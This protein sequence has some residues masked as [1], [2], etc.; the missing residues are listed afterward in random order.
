MCTS[1]ENSQPKCRHCFVVPISKTITIVQFWLSFQWNN[2]ISREKNWRRMTSCIFEIQSKVRKPNSKPLVLNNNGGK[3]FNLN[4]VHSCIGVGKKQKLMVLFWE[5]ISEERKIF[6]YTSKRCPKKPHLLQSDISMFRV[7]HW[8]L[9]II[10]H[11]VLFA[12]I[13]FYYV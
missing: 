7:Q 11:M 3:C 4:L 2:L 9:P 6:L 12:L 8:L 10:T 5:V 1:I 13:D